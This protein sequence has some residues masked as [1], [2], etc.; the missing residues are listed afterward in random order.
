[1]KR[2]AWVLLLAG[3]SSSSAEKPPAD[4]A[5]SELTMAKDEYAGYHIS[6]EGCKKFVGYFEPVVTLD[7]TYI[8]YT[9]RFRGAAENN[10]DPI[11]LYVD[12]AKSGYDMGV[13]RNKKIVA[14]GRVRAMEQIGHERTKGWD[15]KKPIVADVLELVSIDAHNQEIEKLKPRV[16]PNR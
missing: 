1:M 6:R 14:V 11:L 13:W 9:W 4:P 2:V 15:T 3:C 16:E 5:Q 10:A 7:E 12:H 8:K